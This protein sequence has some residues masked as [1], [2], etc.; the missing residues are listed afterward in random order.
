MG[1]DSL[2]LVHRLAHAFIFPLQLF[3]PF[4]TQ[5]TLVEQPGALD[6]FVSLFGWNGNLNGAGDVETPGARWCRLV[7]DIRGVE[8]LA[9]RFF[10][11]VYGR[12]AS[13][14]MSH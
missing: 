9:Y 14:G 1:I 5:V 8:S 6:G 12:F 2:Q 3:F 11:G 10:G 13:R 4:P 7:G